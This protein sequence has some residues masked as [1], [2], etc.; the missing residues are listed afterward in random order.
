MAIGKT[1]GA[2]TTVQLGGVTIRYVHTEATSPYS[3]IEWIAPAGAQ[4][5]PVHVHHGTDEGFYVLTGTYEFLLDDERIE[6]SAGAHVLVPKGRPHTFWNAG[7][8]T[9]NCLIV[10][11]PPGGTRVPTTR[12]RP[13]AALEP[14][15]LLADPEIYAILVGDGHSIVATRE[16]DRPSA[17]SNATTSLTS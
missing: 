8:E 17:W 2:G 12:R 1:S 4:N 15:K 13:R 3:L 16:S 11:S 5:P 14:R 6:A 10:M 7:G 9:A